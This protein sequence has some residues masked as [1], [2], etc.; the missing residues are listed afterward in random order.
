MSINKARIRQKLANLKSG[1]AG[2]AFWTPPKEGGNAVIRAFVPPS[3]EDPFLELWFHFNV[4][5][6]SIYCPKRNG[7]SNNCPI[8][9]LAEELFRGDAN[10]K[11][12]SKQLYARPRYY[13]TIIDRADDVPTPKYWGFGKTI[14]LKLLQWLSED[15][16]GDHE[17]FLDPEEGLDLV[18]TVT[19]TPGKT[20][21]DTSV[22]CKRRESPLCAKKDLQGL[23]SALKSAD[24]IF[25]C[26]TQEEIRNKLD[27]W[28]NESAN[29]EAPKSASEPPQHHKNIPHT[30]TS[31]QLDELFDSIS[32]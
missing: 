19:K 21:A 30:V 27:L 1:A 9:D 10:D 17:K 12:M 11:A 16:G 2:N 31:E 26:P 8:C 14:Y 15:D 6:Q 29:E 18:V 23:Y 25:P 20:F 24:E 3:V 22:D 13:A 7:K 4:G 32:A 5:K 28:L